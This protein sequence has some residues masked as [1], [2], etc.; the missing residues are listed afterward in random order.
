M[1]D[2]S[3]KVDRETVVEKL[4]ERDAEMSDQATLAEIFENGI[5]GYQ[6]NTND[7]LKT[8]YKESIDEDA[9]FNF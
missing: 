7:E 2:T 4:A 3:K 9:I 6:N 8:F 5:N 1:T